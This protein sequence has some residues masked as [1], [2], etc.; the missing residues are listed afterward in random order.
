MTEKKPEI[1]CYGCAAH[2]LNLLASDLRK[3]PSVSVTLDN[4]R[5]IANFFKSRSL[6]KQVLKK[7]AKEKYGKELSVVLGCATRWSTD[8]FMIRKLY[9]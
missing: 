5:R 2:V 3:I 1:T 6:A 9:E 4:N 7:I 8:H